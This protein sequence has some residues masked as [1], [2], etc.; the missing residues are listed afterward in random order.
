M[1]LEVHLKEPL[2]VS[3]SC[4]MQRDPWEL[5]GASWRGAGEVC[6]GASAQQV[7]SRDKDRMAQ[8]S[9][10]HHSKVQITQHLEEREWML[11]TSLRV[12]NLITLRVPTPLSPSEKAIA[13]GLISHSCPRHQDDFLAP[14][15]WN[16][17]KP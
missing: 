15:L 12:A 6:S 9:I 4:H 5:C 11:P 10:F 2:S 7:L 16:R 3:Y 1:K 14:F 17:G 13:S 8:S